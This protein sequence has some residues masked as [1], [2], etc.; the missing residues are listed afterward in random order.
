MTEHHPGT[1][2][3]DLVV[4]TVG[5][6]SLA[7]LL[8]ALAA[9]AGP[10]PGRLLLVDDRRGDRAGP[11]LRAAPPPRLAGRLSVVR[12]RAAGPA[13]A[14]NLGWRR[15][16]APWV[17]FLDDDVEPGPTWLADLAADLAGLPPKVAG[18]QGRL[19][20]PLPAARRP[21]DWERNVHGLETARWATADMAYRRAVLA[22]VGG[23]DERFPR[24]Y[25]EDA[26]LALRV[27]GAG[28]RIARGRRLVTHPVRRADRLVSVR[29][30]AGNAD[31]VLMG[32]LH[33]RGWREAAGVPRGRRPRHLAVT[34]AGL[35]ALGALA[36]RRAG[37][38]RW[39]VPVAV[40][41]GA[42]WLLG[43]AELAWTRIAPG[44]RTPD[45]VATMAATSLLLPPVATWHWLAGW[46]RRRLL[47]DTARAPR[48]HRAR[49]TGAPPRAPNPSAPAA[50]LFDRD[51][52][53]VVDVPY[54]GDPERVVP[55]PGAREALARLRAAGIPTAVVSNQSGVARGRL[56]PEQVEAVNRR[57]EELLGPLGPWLLCQHGPDDGCRCRKPAPGLVE[58]AAR[59][60]GVEPHDCVV[61]GDVGAD[62][63]AASAAG[64]RPVLVPTPATRAEEVATAPEVA[65]DL[66]E[67]V[68][69]LLGPAPPAPVATGSAP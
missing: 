10:L 18:S 62:V 60:L 52:T 11:L 13:A 53:L 17:G 49:S 64:A 58:A 30:Q 22:E 57:V 23:F 34:A 1:P 4:P 40:L 9:A 12:G 44:P 56:R 55:M 39:T 27:L 35:A 6:D 68:D 29:L 33:G 65:G 45:E 50:V 36:A 66:T 48:P 54:N 15:A 5:R 43:T 32:A 20:V 2:R 67:A 63:E 42:G 3:F 8:A 47:A 14:R 46:R 21:T 59:A 7:R 31:D 41:A 25:R 69:L 28:H 19:R 24:A 26:D 16:E 61:I 51:G 37:R 38:P